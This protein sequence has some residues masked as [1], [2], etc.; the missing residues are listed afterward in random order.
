MSIGIFLLGFVLFLLG[1]LLFLVA[2]FRVHILWGLATLLI[3]LVGFVF[4]IVHWGKAWKSFALILFSMAVMLFGLFRLGG[5]LGD[6]I[7]ERWQELRDSQRSAPLQV[8]APNEIYH[9]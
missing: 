9:G 8:Y 6:E 2:A 3:P 7:Y 1:N 5:Q 4:L